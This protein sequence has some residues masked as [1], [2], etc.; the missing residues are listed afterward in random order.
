MSQGIYKIINIVNNKFYIGSS[1][2]IEQRWKTHKKE[3]K[4]GVHHSRH[5]QNAWNKYGQENFIIE[6]IEEI[7]N[8]EFLLIKEQAYIDDKKPHYNVL[9]NVDG[10]KRIFT[11]EARQKMS[12]AKK[13]KKLSDEHKQKIKSS[14]SGINNYMY[15]RKHSIQTKNKISQKLKNRKR[16]PFTDEHKNK[17]RKKLIGKKHTWKN[18]RSK[19]NY[20]QILLIKQLFLQKQKSINELSLMFDV[21]KNTI[22]N[23]INRN[24]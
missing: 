6:I 8:L 12:L 15:G 2:N 17:I 16:K 23:A 22:R 7:V 9:L 5:L 19:L 1:I 24:T 18:G 3:L 20:D 4:R 14:N 21:H 13:G 11:P 10:T